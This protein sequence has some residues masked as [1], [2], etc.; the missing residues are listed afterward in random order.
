MLLQG[1]KEI[2]LEGDAGMAGGHDAVIDEPARVGR[3]EMA[4]E[5]DAGA[6]L[7]VVER[8]HAERHVGG[9]TRAEG[10]MAGKPNRGGATA[11]HAHNTVCSRRS[12]DLLGGNNCNISGRTKWA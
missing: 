3:T 9:M 5:A 2:E 1:R 8:D 12:H 10:L 11:G 4:V 6:R 7:G